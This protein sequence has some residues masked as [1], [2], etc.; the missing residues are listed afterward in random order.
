MLGRW[1]QLEQIHDIHEADFQL[2]EL[3]AQ[4]GRRGQRL[5]GRYIAGR[6]KDDIRL[7]ALIVTCP[8]P[9]PNTLRAVLNRR[10]DI[11]VLKVDLLVRNDHV[12]VVLT[13]QAMI[14]DRQQAIAIGRQID[15][16]DGSALVQD[17]VEESGILMS[18]SVVILAPYCR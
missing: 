8:L 3:L 15:S 4:Q 16:S 11:E 12:D 9:D 18:K 1:F 14:S 2:R 17:H 10:I 6:R 5:L 13:P 7:A